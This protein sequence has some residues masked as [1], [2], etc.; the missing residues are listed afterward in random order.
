MTFSSPSTQPATQQIAAALQWWRDA[1]LD[2][3]FCD[4][5]SNWLAA[6]ELA[7]PETPQGYTAPPPPPAAPRLQFGG[8]ALDWPQDLAAFQQWWLTEPS[9]DGGQLAGRV[10][11]RETAQA[12]LMVLTDYP[13]ANV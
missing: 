4:T 11:P 13:E 10:A 1:G 7:E 2:Q 3:Q 8:A 12:E 5:P 9:L 6:P